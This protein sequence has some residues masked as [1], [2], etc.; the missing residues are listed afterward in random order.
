MI[1]GN[2]RERGRPAAWCLPAVGRVESHTRWG[3]GRGRAGIFPAPAQGALGPR[4]L[5][6]AADREANAGVCR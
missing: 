5:S 4:R 3:L 6:A 1:S 2:N